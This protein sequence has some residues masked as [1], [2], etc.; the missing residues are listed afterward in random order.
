MDTPTL[1]ATVAALCAIGGS[2]IA[3]ATFWMKFSDRI[4]KA[5]DKAK[6]AEAAA[7]NAVIRGEA[8]NIEVDRLRSE[9]VEHRVAVAKEYVSKETLT[10]LESRVIE[11]I[12][13]LGQRLDNLFKHTPNR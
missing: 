10:S 8:L 7:N 1:I 3:F 11:A 2:A 13:N 4:T 12:N 5:D 6:A 9:V